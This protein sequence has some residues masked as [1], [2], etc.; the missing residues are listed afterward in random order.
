MIHTK[1]K[2][3][4]PRTAKREWKPQNKDKKLKKKNEKNTH[5][6]E[7][8]I[9]T[10]AIVEYGCLRKL[11]A[12]RFQSTLTFKFVVYTYNIYI[13]I[14][15]VFGRCEVD[16]MA[17]WLAG[18]MDGLAYVSQSFLHSLGELLRSPSYI[19]ISDHREFTI[20]NWRR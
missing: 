18:W 11:A 10:P 9:L 17:G 8:S 19:V 2:R 20:V 5:N 7:D 13:P 15:F 12:R 1:Y 4:R 3:Y 14:Y 16:Y 6:T